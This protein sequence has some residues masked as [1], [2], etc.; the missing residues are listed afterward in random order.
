M[1]PI[2]I[3]AEA[4]QGFE[5][6]ATLA[7]MLV[8]AAARARADQVKFQL[9]Y[10]DELAVASYQHYELFRTLEMSDSAWASVAQHARDEG[11]GI[12]FDVYGLR[13]LDLA[14]SLGAQAVK[15]HA[16]DFFNDRLMTAALERA[17]HVY[18]SAGGITVEEVESLLALLGASLERLTLLYGFQA[19]PTALADNH[20][21][22]LAAL[23]QRLPGVRLGFM[24]HAAGDSDEASWLGVLAVPLASTVIE[25]HIT[26]DPALRLEDWVSALGPAEFATYVRR[27]RA[28]ELAM[29]ER[30]LSLTPAESAYRRRAVKVVIATRT[31][32]PTAPIE[33]PDVTLLRAGV[34]SERRPV[35]RIAEVI[36]RRVTGR[37]E[38]GQPIYE[39]QLG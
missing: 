7:R 15:I 4:A 11:I 13:S 36:G 1:P 14:L 10:A 17:P 23:R 32:T 20:M 21:T 22:R 19:E 3:V 26:L 31:L 16:T 9:V 38:A 35:E 2:V 28:A 18:L 8:R 37:I 5:G 29:G 6:D 12:A 33:S 34:S 24:D 39:D 27:I 30:D 25:K